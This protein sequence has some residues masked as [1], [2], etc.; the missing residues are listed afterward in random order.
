[1]PTLQDLFP[2]GQGDGNCHSCGCPISSDQQQRHLDW[3]EAIY[4]AT[5]VS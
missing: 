4:T 3:H 2:Y 5:D 1:M